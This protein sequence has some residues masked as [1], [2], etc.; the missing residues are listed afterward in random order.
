MLRVQQVMTQ[1]VQCCRADDSLECA[2]RA[3]WDHDVGA[4]AVLDDSGRPIAMITDRDACM[5][6]YI[7]GKPLSQLRVADVMSKS[8]AVARTTD[9]V[10]DAEQAMKDHQVRRIPVLDA[11]GRLAGILSQN[12]LLREAARERESPNKEITALEVTATLAAVGMPRVGALAT[13]TR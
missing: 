1:N 11:D 4:V 13:S 10:S 7:N 3:M 9:A 5:A 8:L 2:V 12:D 6:A